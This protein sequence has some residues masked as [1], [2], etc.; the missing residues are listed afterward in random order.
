MHCE[1]SDGLHARIPFWY[2]K[3]VGA[4]GFQKEKCFQKVYDEGYSPLSPIEWDD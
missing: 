3:W 1:S 2:K 4:M